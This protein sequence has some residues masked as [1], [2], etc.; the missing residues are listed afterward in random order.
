[1]KNKKII[2]NENEVGKEYI[3]E[4]EEIIKIRKDRKKIY[5]NSFLTEKP[6]SLLTIIKGKISRFINS[7][8]LENRKDSLR[9]CVNYI[10]FLLCVLNKRKEEKK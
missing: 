1:M 2:I 7:N 6:E 4:L 8:D 5:G 9:D 3:E 10:I